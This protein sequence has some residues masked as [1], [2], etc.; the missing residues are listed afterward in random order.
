MN[1]KE[2]SA[3]VEYHKIL[4][5]SL[6][7]SD[8]KLRPEVREALL[9]I[10]DNFFEFLDIPVTII[11]IIVTGSQANYHYTPHSDLDLH[12]I[13]PYNEIECEQPIHELFDSKRKLWKMEHTIGIHG[14]P[15]ECYA[16]DTE[17]PVK[18]SSYSL[19]KNHW[20]HKPGDPEPAAISHGEIPRLS[21][22][23]TQLITEAI[24]QRDLA[25]LS[26]LKQ[27]LGAYRKLGLAKQG[28]FGRANIIFKTLRNS[29][30][31]AALHDAHNTLQ[32][33]D[34][35]VQD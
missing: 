14:V 21:S 25:K 32:D 27:M 6:W 18:G 16:E 5:P 34:L 2:F 15:V 17:Q 8:E 10:A 30:V 29:G 3:G 33:I 11:D 9:R 23:L 35:S 4:N 7:T 13:V 20:I 28:E 19:K 1:Y 31:I 26:K 22:A 24:K 12:I